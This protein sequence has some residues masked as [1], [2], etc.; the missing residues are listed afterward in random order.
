MMGDM[1]VLYD[2]N[3]FISYTF[4][5]VGMSGVLEWLDVV[6]EVRQAVQGL[7]PGAVTRSSAE[8][9]LAAFRRLQALPD[10]IWDMI[11]PM[12]ID[13]IAVLHDLCADD[14]DLG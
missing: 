12:L 11:E 1:P 6:L 7:Q 4:N 3:V 10:E 8:Q 5:D 14:K 13:E 9:C 2:T